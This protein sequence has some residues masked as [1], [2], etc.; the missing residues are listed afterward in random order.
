MND[1]G[2]NIETLFKLFL[3]VIFM[4]AI[5]GAFIFGN[6]IEKQNSN[7]LMIIHSRLNAIDQS[8]IQSKKKHLLTESDVKKWLGLTSD[9]LKSLC[10]AGLAVKIGAGKRFY[11]EK[12]IIDFI[13]ANG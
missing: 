6:F 7:H 4:G 5:T 9:E 11:F 3:S 13:M 2:D 10:E 8:I 1:K 12:N